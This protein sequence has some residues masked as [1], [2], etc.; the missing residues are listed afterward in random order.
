MLE[1]VLQARPIAQQIADE[2]GH[3]AHGHQQKQHRREQEA[4]AALFRLLRLGLR[5][6]LFLFFRFFLRLRRLLIRRT[7]RL[8]ELLRR[9][10]PGRLLRQTRQL[11]LLC[12]FKRHTVI[13]AAKRAARLIGRINCAAIAANDF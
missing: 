13:P 8:L 5:L 4:P 9:L 10:L 6:L 11:R 12:I 7:G 3:H 1:L 2:I